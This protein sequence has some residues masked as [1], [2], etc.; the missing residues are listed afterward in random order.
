MSPHS[1]GPRVP[2]RL[3]GLMGLME[4]KLTCRVSGHCGAVAAAWSRSVSWTRGQM[5]ISLYPDFYWGYTEVQVSK[6]GDTLV[7]WTMS[8]T[9]PR[10]RSMF[11]FVWIFHGPDTGWPLGVIRCRSPAVN[12]VPHQ[13]CPSLSALTLGGGRCALTSRHSGGC[14]C[15]SIL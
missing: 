2:G 7:T 4:R 5:G 15:A 9:Q 1:R 13:L 8:V 6:Y 3:M 10:S 14:P 11:L 12:T